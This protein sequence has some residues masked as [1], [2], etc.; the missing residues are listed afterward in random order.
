MELEEKSDLVFG[1]H[2]IIE[3]LESDKT[4][5]KILILNTLRTYNGLLCEKITDNYA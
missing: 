1:I 2:P 3:G 5:D 4:F